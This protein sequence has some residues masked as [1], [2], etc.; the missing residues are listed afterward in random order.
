MTITAKIVA[1]SVWPGSPSVITTMGLRYPR[2]VHPEFLTHRDFSRGASSSRAIPIARMIAD[3][4]A[5]IAM[6]VAWGK[7]QP[8]MQARELLSPEDAAQARQVWLEAAEEAVWQAKRLDALGAHKQIVN[9]V[10]EPFSH[11]SVVVTSTAWDNFFSLRC[12]PDA[13]PTMQALADA[14]RAAMQAS[15]P[16]T[17][18]EGE[19]HAPYLPGGVGHT[20]E[21]ARICAA[22]CA[23]VSYLNHDGSEPDLVADLELAHRLYVSRHMSPFEHAAWPTPGERH[24]N[25][26]GWQ[27]FR[28]QIEVQAA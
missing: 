9:R 12:H 28:N 19:F 14:M 6:P 23:R 27:S 17:L 18:I 5:D 13:D 3:V 22:R 8:G 16:R 4:E 26:D 15:T 10:L 2:F 21:E 7:N 11:I 24:A 25:F 20:E 1:Q